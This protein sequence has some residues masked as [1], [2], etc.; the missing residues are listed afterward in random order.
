LK[1]LNKAKAS[2]A[3]IEDE[4]NDFYNK[5]RDRSPQL[6]TTST[7]SLTHMDKFARNKSVFSKS[8][9]SPISDL[10]NETHHSQK[11]LRFKT[12]N[13]RKNTAVKRLFSALNY[14]LKLVKFNNFM[15][16]KRFDGFML[17]SSNDSI[18]KMEPGP[19]D[20]YRQKKLEYSQNNRTLRPEKYEEYN[21]SI[22]QR[23]PKKNDL[24]DQTMQEYLEARQSID[25]AKNEFENKNKDSKFRRT[26]PKQTKSVASISC[27]AENDKNHN[28]KKTR[29]LNENRKSYVNVAERKLEYQKQ[30]L[31]LHRKS[32]EDQVSFNPSSSSK[33]I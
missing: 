28:S 25:V 9:N 14:H 10:L 18:V 24:F 30:M 32:V 33:N 23:L 20:R 8:T 2:R 4:N 6:G 17:L 5:Y 21:G 3:T 29:L 27:L 16:I 11:Y 13:I 26:S 7:R 19:S 1:K 12:M 22:T 15:T 31:D